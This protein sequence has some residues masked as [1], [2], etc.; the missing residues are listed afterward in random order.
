LNTP[1]SFRGADPQAVQAYFEGNGWTASPGKQ[2]VDYPVVKLEPN[3]EGLKGHQIRIM[4]GGATRPV[5]I[6]QGPHM[7]INGGSIRDL[8]IPLKGTPTL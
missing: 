8:I 5:P 6:K 3:N 7:I 1:N 2:N 4:P